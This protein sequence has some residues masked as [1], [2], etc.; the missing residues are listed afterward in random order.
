MFNRV[1]ESPRYDFNHIDPITGLPKVKRARH[2]DSIH[3]MSQY[4]SRSGWIVML[5]N[6][7]NFRS[8]G[9]IQYSKTVWYD[10][11]THTVSSDETMEDAV[12]FR[13]YTLQGAGHPGGWLYKDEHQ[14]LNE[15]FF[16]D[17][18]L[19][20]EIDND[21]VELEDNQSQPEEYKHK[22][23]YLVQANKYSF[24][25]KLIT[26]NK[27]YNLIKRFEYMFDSSTELKNY[28]VE[29][30]VV[31]DKKYDTFPN[32]KY[33]EENN[34]YTLN[35][36]NITPEGI[37]DEGHR[38]ELGTYKGVMI[39]KSNPEKDMFKVNLLNMLQK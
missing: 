9:N 33:T 19:D 20:N 16:D 4:P 28:N 38:A 34:Q 32:N 36:K 7:V 8:I 24:D 21:T 17:V 2:E 37:L 31:V 25:D 23:Q 27:L 5:N 1:T 29:F 35:S 39:S 13:T 12:H 18:D 3:L 14:R 15:D 26:N 30:R 22:F 10:R 6:R 11:A